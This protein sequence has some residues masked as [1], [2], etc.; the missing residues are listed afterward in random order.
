MVF[1]FVQINKP[2]I[3]N[4]QNCYFWSEGWRSPHG[5][6]LSQ[7]RSV[8]EKVQILI[9]RIWTGRIRSPMPLPKPTILSSGN[10]FAKIIL[11]PTWPESIFGACVQQLLL[12][13]RLCRWNFRQIN[14]KYNCD[15]FLSDWCPCPLQSPKWIRFHMSDPINTNLFNLFS[16]VQF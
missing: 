12:S 14:L 11:Q 5:L 6:W 16:E 13:C 4:V 7:L 15:W 10:L 8:S 9:W 2:W 1:I 3:Y